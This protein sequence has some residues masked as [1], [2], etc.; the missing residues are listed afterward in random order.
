LERGRQPVLL[1]SCSRPETALTEPPLPLSRHCHSASVIRLVEGGAYRR[2]TVIPNNLIELLHLR[3]CRYEP[4]P[5][6]RLAKGIRHDGQVILAGLVWDADELGLPGPELDLPVESQGRTLGRFVLD[7]TPA[8]PV[9]HRKRLV[10]V[11]LADQVGAALQRTLR[12]A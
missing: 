7:P 10:A 12:S 1:R 5:G 4:G 9:S 6:Q 8:L 2:S 3:D 11:A